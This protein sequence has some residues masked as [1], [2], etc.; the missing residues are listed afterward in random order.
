M[1]TPFKM[2]Y[3]SFCAYRI[4]LTYAAVFQVWGTPKDAMVIHYFMTANKVIRKKYK[5]VKKSA[6]TG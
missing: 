4:F 2:V 6:T 5:T 3:S 1:N